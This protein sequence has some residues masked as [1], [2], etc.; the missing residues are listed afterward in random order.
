MSYWVTAFLGL[1]SNLSGDDGTVL[2]NLRAARWE[3]GE[4]D[5]LRIVSVSPVYG[6]APW[7]VAE[8][9]DFLNAV[10]VGRTRLEPVAL[11][12]TLLRLEAE[13]GRPP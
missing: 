6:S 4:I 1:G 11:L 2:E 5:G 3:L 7:G 12:A 10:A 8:Q 9:P 13:A